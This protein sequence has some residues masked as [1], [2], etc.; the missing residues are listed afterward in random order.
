MDLNNYTLKGI[1]FVFIFFSLLLIPHYTQAD[2][3]TNLYFSGY[4]QDQAVG[5]DLSAGAWSAPTIYD[6][7]NDGAKDLLV[8]MKSSGVGYVKYYKNIGTDAAPSF[9]GYINIQA[10]NNT[11]LLNVPAAAG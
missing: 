11:C 5:G 6:W 9:N 4:I 10:C 1:V 2:Y 7:D 3:S 8:G